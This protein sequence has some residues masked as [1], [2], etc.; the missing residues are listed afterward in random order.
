MIF[1]EGLRTDCEAGSFARMAQE[2][3]LIDRALRDVRSADCLKGAEQRL[4]KTALRSRLDGAKVTSIFAAAINIAV[5]SH[6]KGHP[7]RRIMYR[8]YVLSGD[9]TRLGSLLADAYLAQH[10]PQPGVSR[11]R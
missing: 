3:T 8:N 11:P 5:W 9:G 6:L 1:F 10:A 7:L 4:Q 2:T